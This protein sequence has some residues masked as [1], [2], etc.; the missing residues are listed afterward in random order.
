MSTH[1]YHVVHN[2]HWYVLC[3]AVRPECQGHG[4]GRKLMNAVTGIADLESLPCFLET[5]GERNKAIYKCF[6][7]EVA[8]EHTIEVDDSAFEEE[9]SKPLRVTMELRQP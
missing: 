8:G 7:Y 6:G 1:H 9:C 4:L 3:F 2:P 5:C